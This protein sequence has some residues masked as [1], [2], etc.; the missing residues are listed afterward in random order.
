MPTA[1]LSASIMITLEF[2]RA[3]ATVTHG[4][5]LALS[6]PDK[7]LQVS[8]HGLKDILKRIGRTEDQRTQISKHPST[9]LPQ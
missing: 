6:G 8:A 9:T 5:P 4:L 3:S 2:P 7:A 1:R